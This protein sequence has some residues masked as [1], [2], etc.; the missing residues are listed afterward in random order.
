MFTHKPDSEMEM[1]EIVVYAVLDVL[2]AV[3]SEGLLFKITGRILPRL[4]LI[5]QETLYQNT[6]VCLINGIR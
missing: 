5:R 4:L 6:K 3:E 1:E 2:G